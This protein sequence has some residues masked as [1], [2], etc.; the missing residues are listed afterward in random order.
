MDSRGGYVSKI[1][2]VKMKECGPF[3]GRAP[4][5]P[6]LDLPMHGLTD[7]KHD[8]F[9]LK[10]WHFSTTK[11]NF[12]KEKKRNRRLKECGATE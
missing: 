3:W 10:Y 6:P 8:N 4:G 2:Y 12:K 9:S 1:L 5:T 11:D 7:V